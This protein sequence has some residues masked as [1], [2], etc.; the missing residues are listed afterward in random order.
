[1]MTAKP[2]T[3]CAGQELQALHVSDRDRSRKE[4]ADLEL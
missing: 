1:M 2:F 3:S 4:Q